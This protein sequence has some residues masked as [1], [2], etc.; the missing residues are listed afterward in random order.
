MPTT[1]PLKNKKPKAPAKRVK[2]ELAKDI[3]AGHLA[4]VIPTEVEGPVSPIKNQSHETFVPTLLGA[5]SIGKKKYIEGIGRRKTSTAR[6]RIYDG[7]GQWVING[8]DA[9]KYFSK[10]QVQTAVAPLIQIRKANKRDV[11]VHVSGGGP[12]GQAV[13]IRHGL[14]RALLLEDEAN[15]PVLKPLGF[16]TRDPRAKERKK[17]GLRRARRAPQF[18]KR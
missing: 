11:S 7:T 6:V 12:N 10:Q 5:A 17:F 18:S 15:L 16:L 4:S 9:S 14:S 1:T 13:A 8:K 2:K 3:T